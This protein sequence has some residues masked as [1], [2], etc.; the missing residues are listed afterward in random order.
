MLRNKKGAAELG[1][2]FY[3][4]VYLFAAAILIFILY[5]TYGQVKEP[6]QTAL[7]GGVQSSS[8]EQLNNTIT[9]MSNQTTSGIGMFSTLFPF[10]LLGLIGMVAVS[11][12]FIDSHPIFFFASL[13]ILGVVILVAVVFSN[14]FET[15][16][17][18][19]SFGDTADHLT[20]MKLF[21]K[22]LPYIALLTILIVA[23]ILWGKQSGG[24]G[25]GL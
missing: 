14:I 13:I 8:Q 20:V 18:D 15:I 2:V 1:D 17:T 25:G 16:I 6:I 4:I 3:V 9:A 5:F 21:M 12:L 10:L 23:I 7:V 22:N 24:V 11:A 19:T